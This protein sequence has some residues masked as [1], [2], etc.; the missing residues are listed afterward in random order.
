M[1]VAKIPPQGRK[2]PDEVNIMSVM[3]LTHWPLEYL[4]SILGR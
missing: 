1:Q 3:T 2:E 4:N